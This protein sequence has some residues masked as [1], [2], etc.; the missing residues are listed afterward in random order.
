MSAPIDRPAPDAGQ[1]PAPSSAAPDRST[2]SDAPAP[3]GIQFPP[4]PEPGPLPP[5]G[6]GA[7]GTPPLTPPVQPPPSSYPAPP[8]T[9]APYGAPASGAPY[10]APGSG[11]PYSAPPSSAPYSAPG[12][13]APYGAPGSGAPYSAPPSSAP[14]SAPADDT[15]FAGQR[16]VAYSVDPF[17]VDGLPPGSFP[18]PSAAEGVM[19]DPA[20]SS[21][22][23]QAPAAMADP[24]S[25]TPA[26]GYAPAMGAPH[27]TGAGQ[28]VGASHAMGSGQAVG[29]SH[30]M[31]SGQAVGGAP[32]VAA[33]A[34]VG[35]VTA[36]TPPV[37]P[38]NPKSAATL[39]VPFL[40][41][42]L[43]AA[44][45]GVYGKLHEPTGIAVNVAG[46]S[47]P[48][49]VKVWLTTLAFVLAI[50]QLFT[51]LVMYG[52]I[53]VLKNA[54]WLGAVH[55]WSGRLAFIASIPVALHCLYALGFGAYNTRVLV[56]SLLGCF[57]YGVFTAKMLILTKKG[58]PNWALPVF[59]GFVFTA[60]SGLFV[61][62]ALW[63]FTTFGVKF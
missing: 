21:F 40:I 33:A 7:Y 19:A 56:H 30:A 20:G 24:A 28:V 25:A 37:T 13:S 34:P 51:A 63:F 46:F 9:A 5:S 50:V 54:R 44:G 43:V 45:L 53:P 59:G 29:A 18:P 14:Y 57:F 35:V 41:A 52:K 4:I 15:P 1:I 3:G 32:F 10:S 48:L 8:Q 27:A 2:E 47:S 12:S 60:L 11:A 61:T 38:T 55:R 36:S 16:P 26:M 31:G 22:G 42:C 6:I 17:P 23:A 49:T 62:S 58:V 39:I